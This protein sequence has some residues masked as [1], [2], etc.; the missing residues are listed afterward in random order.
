MR[1]QEPELAALAG[2]GHR[3]RGARQIDAVEAGERIGQET[4]HWD[5][6]DG[7]THTMRTKEDADDYRYFP[8]PDLV[9]VAP[10]PETRA[11]VPVVDAGAAG[12]PRPA[13]AGV[14]DRGLRR[15]G[16]RRHARTRRVRRGSGGRGSTAA[17]R[18]TSAKWSNGEVLGY[19]N[20]SGL[21]PAA[22]PL[23]PDGLAELV[24]LVDAGLISRNQAKTKW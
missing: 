21:V 12:G 22:P 6:A 17:R 15:V 16:S 1:D 19:L 9:P 4:R 13:P 23:S 7:R 18:T 8:E 14:G 10:T 24:G 5:E 11:R 20:E 3:V 2:A